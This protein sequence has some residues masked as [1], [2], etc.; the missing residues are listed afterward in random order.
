MDDPGRMLFD[1]VYDRDAFG[2]LMPEIQLRLLAA[3][4]QYASI[5]PYRPR[6]SA[7][8]NALKRALGGGATTLHGG[9]VYPHKDRLYICAEYNAVKNTKTENGYWR[10]LYLTGD[11]DVR[12][13][14]EKG[15]A[16][17]RETT[18]IPARV[19]WPSPAVWNGD[20]VLGTPRTGVNPHW[21]PENCGRRFRD[22]LTAH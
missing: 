11:K 8:S 16:Q 10:G 5:N 20:R 2:Q 15:A 18:D 1:V 4:L 19:L 22:I 3:S 13:L 7:V 14:G 12:P 6:M 9:Y 17:I 21:N